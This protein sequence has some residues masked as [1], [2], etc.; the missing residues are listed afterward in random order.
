M[1]EFIRA[2]S[3]EQKE[4]RMQEIIDAVEALFQEKP[5]HEITLTTIAEKLSWTR[6][7]LYKYV[8]TK[9]EIF[10]ELS[11]DKRDV[12][13]D[14]F[15]AAFPM[16]CNYSLEVFAEVWAGILNAHRDHLRYSDILSTI[17]ETNV[18]IERLGAFKKR[19]YNRA[20]EISNI[21]AT[22]FNLN[23][24]DAYS[25]LLNVHYHAIGIDSIIRWNPLVTEA[26]AKENITPPNIDFRDNLRFFISMNLSTY[27]NGILKK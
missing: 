13:Y 6:V 12:Y 7:N 2:R 26:L 9:E 18:S 8:A 22:H 5:Y 20:Y 1:T 25:V 19:Y 10:L 27:C 3:E 16:G 24:E 23:S 14:A 17:I 21:I 11:A 15:K 4:Q